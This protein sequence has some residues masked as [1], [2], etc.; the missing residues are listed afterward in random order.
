M[1]GHKH[2]SSAGTQ[3]QGN[4]LGD[5]SCVRQSR[6]YRMHEGGNDMKALLGTPH[7]AW[8]TKQKQGAYE[9]QEVYDHTMDN[10]YGRSSKPDQSY[11]GST[12]SGKSKV[13]GRG[14]Y[15]ED[16]YDYRGSTQTNSYN[17]RSA[18]PGDGYDNGRARQANANNARGSS[19]A[20]Y[21]SQDTYE[22][23]DK[24]AIPANPYSRRDNEENV[25]NG[26]NNAPAYR[27]SAAASSYYQ[28]EE[29]RGYGGYGGSSGS[30]ARSLREMKEQ[31][32]QSSY[33]SM[34]GATSNNNP[35]SLSAYAAPVASNSRGAQNQRD[36]RPW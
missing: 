28:E 9:G 29:P 21:A 26:A 35:L 15:N 25:R 32:D 1:P 19:L 16:E 12:Y 24:Y 36:T 20:S 8:D 33:R 4:T 27:S 34:R 13:G 6:L 31:I 22:R 18:N 2:D 10:P 11:G 23:P 30:N 3:N 7:L 17:N 14:G 5:R